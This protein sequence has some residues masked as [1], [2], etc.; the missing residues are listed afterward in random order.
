MRWSRA[1]SHRAHRDS[2]T[3]CRPS[4]VAQDRHFAQS[5]GEKRLIEA[6]QLSAGSEACV[7]VD[8]S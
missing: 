5:E 3:A 4:T 6:N 7:S 8:K 2:S 1:V